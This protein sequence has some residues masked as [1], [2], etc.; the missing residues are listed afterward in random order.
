[1]VTIGGTGGKLD[2]LARAQTLRKEMENLVAYECFLRGREYLNR[3]RV[4]EPSFGRAGEMFEQA[5]NLDPEFARAYL[6]LAW[7]YIW[8]V[9]S[10]RVSSPQSSLQRAFDLA[11]RALDIESPNNWN[12]W[13]H[14]ILGNIYVWKRAPERAILHCERAMELNSNDAAMLMDLADNWC[15]LGDPKQAIELAERAISLH[16]EHPDVYLWTRLHPDV[17][18]GN[19]A[20]AYFMDQRYHQALS[21]L[22]QVAEPGD[23]SRLLAVTYAMLG[24]VDEARAAGQAFLK[25]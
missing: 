20:F 5:I 22:K 13:S 7:F 21:W 25:E 14:W 16:P 3:Y 12:H 18:R 1:M 11:E 10:G 19:L 23:C 6:G 24:R 2:E 15:Y 8:E 4:R 9:K 17:G